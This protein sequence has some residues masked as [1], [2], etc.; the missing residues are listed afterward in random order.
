MQFFRKYFVPYHIPQCWWNNYMCYYSWCASTS[1]NIPDVPKIQ[2]QEFSSLDSFSLHEQLQQRQ[3]G[4]E[5]I[6]WNCAVFEC[7]NEKVNHAVQ[8]RVK[9][10]KGV[11]KW[12]LIKPER[13]LHVGNYPH[14]FWLFVVVFWNCD[15]DS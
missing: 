2:P 12:K 10:V 4:K 14:I 3:T 7:R 13:S 11:G 8:G 15:N 6:W 5:E 9:E 1:S